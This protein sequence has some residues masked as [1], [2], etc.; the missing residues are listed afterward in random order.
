MLKCEHTYKYF[1]NYNKMI[2]EIWGSWISKIIAYQ[3]K[4]AQY[5]KGNSMAY[6]LKVQD[7]Y[8]DQYLNTDCAIY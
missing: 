5:K 2:M 4:T 3:V 6:W 1:D 8:S 7:L